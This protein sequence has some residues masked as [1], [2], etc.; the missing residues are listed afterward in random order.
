M[1][2]K[3]CF[4]SC[5]WFIWG[6]SSLS[7]SLFSDPF[8]IASIRKLYAHRFPFFPA[9]FSPGWETIFHG[10]DEFDEK[11]HQAK[12]KISS[13]RS[14]EIST[15]NLQNLNK[16]Y[17]NYI[18]ILDFLVFLLKFDVFVK[19]LCAWWDFSVSWDFVLTW[20]FVPFGAP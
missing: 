13:S 6:L 3:S 11:S 12:R 17:V 15:N 8:L 18:S 9:S 20:N 14:T 4:K 19:I 1:L 5:Y 10:T 7:F 16:F 2:G